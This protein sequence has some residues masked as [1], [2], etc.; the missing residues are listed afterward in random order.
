MTSTIDL[1]EMEGRKRF[2]RSS[3]DDPHPTFLLDGTGPSVQ[4]PWGGPGAG[5]GSPIPG[6]LFVWNIC[7]VESKRLVP[8]SREPQGFRV[9]CGRV[10][11]RQVPENIGKLFET[12]TCYYVRFLL[13][14]VRHLLLLAMH[15]LLLSFCD[16]S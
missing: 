10:E 3:S 2:Q 13:L 5:L 16:A 11:E 7:M 6:R 14:L 4:I 1:D 9:V 12:G 8:V 15:L